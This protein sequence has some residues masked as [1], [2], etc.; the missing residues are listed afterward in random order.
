MLFRRT[1]TLLLWTMCFR[2]SRTVLDASCLRRTREPRELFRHWLDDLQ[3]HSE[4][5]HHLTVLS[6]LSGTEHA[7]GVP[8]AV[9]PD[10]L[11]TSW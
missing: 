10:P 4:C 2:C 8:T 11:F 7:R 6:L 1:S 3:Q 5:I 9:V